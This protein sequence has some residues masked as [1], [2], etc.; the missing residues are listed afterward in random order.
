MYW[1][2]LLDRKTGGLYTRSMLIFIDETFRKCVGAKGEEVDFG[3]L[4]GVGIPLDAYSRIATAVYKL[5]LHHMGREYAD[6]HEIKG[7]KLL[8]N[9]ILR[10]QNQNPNDCHKNIDFVAAV[11]NVIQTNKLPVFGCVCFD[12]RN[13][14]FTSENA[15]ALANTF[16][17]LCERINMYM[18]RECPTQRAVIVFDNR[19]SGINERNARAMTNYFVRSKS[20][21]SMRSSILEVPL[22]AISQANNIG[23]ELAD[24]VTTIIGIHASGDVRIG[25]LYEMLHRRFYTWKDNYGNP[26]STLRWLDPQKLGP[27]K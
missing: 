23:L 19:D 5:K 21:N 11:L 4:C 15:T 26:M 6:N 24:L 1:R 12:Q 10:H 2:L 17:S 3:A 9:G 18:K 13:C 27:G 8:A 20:G 22:F 14:R 16:K 25:E 7:K